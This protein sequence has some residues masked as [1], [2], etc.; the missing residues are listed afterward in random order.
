MRVASCVWADRLV[1]VGH[2]L[3]CESWLAQTFGYS[4]IL[5]GGGL[6]FR[7]RL[8]QSGPRGKGFAYA[9]PGK[10]RVLDRC[11]PLRVPL[12]YGRNG[13]LRKAFAAIRVAEPS[14]PRWV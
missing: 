12:H 6:S 7:S 3:S 4:G 5:V 10:R 11:G 9:A 2:E 13:G 14:E 8:F 1:S